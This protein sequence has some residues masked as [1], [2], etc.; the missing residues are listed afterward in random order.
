MDDQRFNGSAATDHDAEAVLATMMLSDLARLFPHH[1][2]QLAAAKPL[3]PRR[4][5]ADDLE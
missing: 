3:L 1:A 2:R 5:N 4:D